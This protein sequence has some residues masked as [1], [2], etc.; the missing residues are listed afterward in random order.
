[1]Q[2]SEHLPLFHSAPWCIV[3]V[4]LAGATIVAGAATGAAA[5]NAFLG[6]AA[7]QSLGEWSRPIA[8]LAGKAGGAVAGTWDAS[9]S[10]APPYSENSRSQRA[11][12]GS[13]AEPHS[14]GSTHLGEERRVAR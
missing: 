8:T 14:D 1:M 12:G 10:E 5:G 6:E 3:P 11:S 7:A 13:E 2:Q 4:A 9:G